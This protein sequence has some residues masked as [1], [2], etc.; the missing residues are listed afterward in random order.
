MV[1]E[2]RRHQEWDSQQ[3]RQH[4][5]LVTADAALFLKGD[6]PDHPSGGWRMIPS[7]HVEGPGGKAG[8]E[9]PNL[10]PTKKA[11]THRPK[12]LTEQHAE[13]PR[14]SSSRSHHIHHQPATM[15][16]SGSKKLTLAP[17]RGTRDVSPAH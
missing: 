1:T 4:K 10:S 12:L 14:A 11:Q 15:S 5:G 8:Q 3:D 2:M 16:G 9:W 13:K 17:H 7:D 6:H